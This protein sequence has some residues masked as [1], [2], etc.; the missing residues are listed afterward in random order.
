[1]KLESIIPNKTPKYYFNEKE[2]KNHLKRYKEY[3]DKSSQEQLIIGVAA[4]INGMINKEF[5]HNKYVKNNRSDM[6]NECVIEVI[7][8]LDRFDPNKGRI[9]AYVN[10]IVKNTLVRAYN[11]NTKIFHHENTFTDIF[12]LANNSCN[13][14]L[15]DN[16]AENAVKIGMHSLRTQDSQEVKVV[17]IDKKRVD[18]SEEESALISYVFFSEANKKLDLLKYDKQIRNELYEHMKTDPNLKFDFK[19][20]IHIYTNIINMASDIIHLQLNWLEFNFPN[21]SETCINLN[22]DMTNFKISK[23]FMR[24]IRKVTRES[25]YLPKDFYDK[26]NIEDIIKFIIYVLN[27]GVLPDV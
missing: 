2:M 11:K 24:K 27:S 21:I 20:N 22:H 16:E 8:S 13:G 17:P 4:V 5:Y 25:K 18:I 1:M 10:R 15:T 19:E 6:I 23:N 14:E 7:K 9:F 12:N 3:N 26:F